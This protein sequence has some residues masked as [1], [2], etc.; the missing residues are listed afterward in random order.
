MTL[1]IAFVKLRFD[2]AATPCWNASPKKRPDFRTICRQIRN[3]RSGGA[4]QENYYAV[5]PKSK[6]YDDPKERTNDYIS[7]RKTGSSPEELYDDTCR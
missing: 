1:N 4:N 7:A 2:I 5:D 6:Q 3:F